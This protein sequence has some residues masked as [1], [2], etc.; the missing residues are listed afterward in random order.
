[1]QVEKQITQISEAR[2]ELLTKYFKAMADISRVRIMALLADKGGVYTV[3]D[4]IKHLPLEQPTVSF[5]LKILLMSG[6]VHK[7]KRGLN[8]YYS[9]NSHIMEYIKDSMTVFIGLER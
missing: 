2:A 8:A 3:N 5:H 6:L 4:I 1:M 9:V 7:E